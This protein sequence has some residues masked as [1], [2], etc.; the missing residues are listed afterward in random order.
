MVTM[1][2]IIHFLA[3]P[4]FRV[5]DVFIEKH[6]KQ[7]YDEL[8]QKFPGTSSLLVLFLLQFFHLSENSSKQ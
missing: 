5:L 7:F 8:Q 4:K 1:L 6:W 3:Q 2:P